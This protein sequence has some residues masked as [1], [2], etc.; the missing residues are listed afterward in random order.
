M[1]KLSPMTKHARMSL[2]L[3]SV[4]ALTIPPYDAPAQVA[5][6]K[7]EVGPGP[8]NLD[9]DAG[10]GEYEERFLHVP[11]S[12]FT[13]KGFIQFTAVRADAKWDPMAAV[14]IMGPKD[15]YSAGLIAFVRHSAPDKIE[16]AVRDPLLR[17][18]P[19]ASFARVQLSDQA[20]PFE[21]RLD[22]SGVLQ[23]SVAGKPGRTVTVRRIEVTR[24]RVFGSTGHIRLSN[25]DI[26]G[27]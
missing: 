11:A 22:K 10:S 23:V 15:S 18:L 2:F 5:S 6:P 13:V 3:L 8:Y 25:I 1:T 21:L 17:G 4:C 9:L 19:D 24:V 27:R 14:E 26:S 20:I 16:F 12:A 7:F